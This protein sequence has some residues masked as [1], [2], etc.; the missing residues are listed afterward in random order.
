MFTAGCS[1]QQAMGSQQTSSSQQAACNCQPCEQAAPV[2]V[3][4][5]AA[6][7]KRPPPPVQV[8][9][10]KAKGAYKGA[11]QMDPASKEVMEQYQR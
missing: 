2:P 4:P 6:P 10:V 3:A 11:V 5:P 8:P 7:V 1:Q 9:Q